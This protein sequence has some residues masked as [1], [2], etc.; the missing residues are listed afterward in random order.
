[1]R[2]TDKPN[3]TPPPAAGQNSCTS[4]A[5][6]RDPNASP[7]SS[8]ER[9]T[10]LSGLQS[11]SS[12]VSRLAVSRSRGRAPAGTLGKT[13]HSVRVLALASADEFASN[14]K[15]PEWRRVFQLIRRIKGI[16]G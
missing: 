12:K 5:E 1:M 2:E 6:N 7:T 10:C 4:A 14:A 16:P 11:S 3:I 9:A 13:L 8:A 15:L